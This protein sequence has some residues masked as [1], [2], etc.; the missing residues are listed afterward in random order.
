[1]YSVVRVCD[2]NNPTSSASLLSVSVVAAD[3]KV[4]VVVDSDKKSSPL[5]LLRPSSEDNISALVSKSRHN[6]NDIMDANPNPLAN[7]V[8]GIIV[9][10]RDDDDEIALSAAAAA[11]VV[12]A[13]CVVVMGNNNV[14]LAV[15]NILSKNRLPHNAVAM[16]KLRDCDDNCD[17]S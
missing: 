15:F 16:P 6:R 11:V 9:A 2:A 4:V 7:K 14:R 5:L 8:V 17:D 12:V 3:D 1:M 10:L 13:D